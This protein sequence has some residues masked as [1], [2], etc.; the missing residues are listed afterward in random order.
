LLLD[1]KL[2]HEWIVI[3][4]K[5]HALA[6]NTVSNA[7]TR[8]QKHAMENMLITITHLGSPEKSSTLS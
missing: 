3:V 5:N 1:Q 8:Q 4:S 6:K 2:D 7:T